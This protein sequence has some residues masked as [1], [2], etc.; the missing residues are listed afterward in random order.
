[1]RWDSKLMV[2]GLMVAA[3]VELMVVGNQ[4]DSFGWSHGGRVQGGGSG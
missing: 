1:M 3:L 4:G 2:V